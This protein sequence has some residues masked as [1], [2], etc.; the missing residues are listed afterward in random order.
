MAS[1]EDGLIADLAGAILDGSAID[2]TAAESSADLAERTLLDHLRLV[3]TV[4]NL[5]RDCSRSLPSVS[6]DTHQ[7]VPAADR[8]GTLEHWGH[9]RVLERIGR[10]VFGDVYRAW[11]TKLDREVALKLMPEN[12]SRADPNGTAIVDEGR[13]L[14]RVRHPN[15]VTIY[16]A[17]RIENRI[18]LWMELVKGRTLQQALEDGRTFSTTEVVDIGIELCSAVAA[19]HDAGLLHRDI[20]PH[21]V[22]LAD[23]GRVV[24]MDFGTGREWR[25]RASPELAGTPLYLAPELLCRKDPS[26]VSDIYSLGVLLFHLLTRTYPVRAQSLSDLRL[27]HERGGSTNVRL[28]RPDVSPKLARVIAR[29]IDSMPGRRYQTAGGLAADLFSLKPRSRTVPLAYAGAALAAIVLLA[30]IGTEIRARRSDARS[31]PGAAAASIAA[32]SPTER[33]VIAVLP[34]K[35]LSPEPDSDYLADGLTDEILRNLA[36]IKG[37]EVRSRISSFM[38]RDKPRNLREVGEQLGANLVVEGSVLRSGNRLRVNAQL[39]QVAGDMP[40]W[41]D[42]FDRDLQ[43]IFAIQEEISRA[44]VNELRLT[45]GTGQRR[46]DTNVEAYELY[47][48]AR[49]ML[50]RRGE[51]PANPSLKAAELFQQVIDKDPVFAPAYAGLANAHAV[52]SMSPYRGP[53]GNA[54]PFKD[55][56]AIVRTAAVQAVKLDP[57]LAEAHAAIG[58]VYAREFDWENAERS[59]RRALDLDTTLSHVYVNY[60]WTTLR[61]LEKHEE[62]ERLLRTALGHDPLSHN[63]RRELAMTLLYAG[64]YDEAVDNFERVRAVDPDFP[65]PHYARALTLAGR[66]PEAISVLGTAPGNAPWLGYAYV[67]AGRR[68]DAERLAVVHHHLPFRAANIYAALGDKDRAFEALERMFTGEPQRLAGTLVAP[69][70]ALLHGDPRLADLRKKLRLP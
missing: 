55:T 56:H 26:F 23:D 51:G 4:A 49:A 58:W 29:A 45:L 35:N 2:W 37:L 65:I 66:A 50:D 39:V 28:V 8:T 41:A 54:I 19:V 3:A 22:M 31:T 30:W 43:D 16:G 21:N 11:D 52:R 34:L 5:Y 36:V 70:M 69:E 47:L 20:K 61:P 60:V 1:S 6:E 42:R 13:L 44:I 33:P 53:Q 64:R 10:G 62:A 17:D 40:L 27:A 18:G 59:F 14:A 67:K 48:K 12:G 38:F 32:V 63:L 24:L 25:D 46:Y 15:V 68:A 57:L 7:L 9:L